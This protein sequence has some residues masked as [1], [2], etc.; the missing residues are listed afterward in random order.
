[1]F[2]FTLVNKGKNIEENSNAYV[3]I[4]DFEYGYSRLI[5]AVDQGIF[6]NLDFFIKD[7]KYQLLFWTHNVIRPLYF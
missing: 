1:M 2:N 4:I 5:I 3:G 7:K 6:R